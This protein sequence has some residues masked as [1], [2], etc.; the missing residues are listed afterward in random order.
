MIK[1]SLRD[2][3]KLGKHQELTQRGGANLMSVLKSSL[4]IWIR[5]YK[6]DFD[7]FFW[8]GEGGGNYNPNLPCV[9]H[10]AHSGAP[11]PICAATMW[12]PN[13]C[14]FYTNPSQ[15]QS[16]MGSLLVHYNL[17][18]P[19]CTLDSSVCH[20]FMLIY[21]YIIRKKTQLLKGICTML[22]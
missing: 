6:I 15:L 3:K 13:F 20:L 14:I 10:A 19:P 17:V 7:H 4:S 5:S 1:S 2:A 16:H 11:S 8:K 12:S 9:I 21:L 18:L 22:L